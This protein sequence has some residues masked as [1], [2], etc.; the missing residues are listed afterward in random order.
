MSK[1]KKKVFSFKLTN[2]LVPKETPSADNA[3]LATEG[4]RIYFRVIHQI[5]LRRG[6]STQS[7]VI[8]TLYP[9][10]KTNEL[11]QASEYP[12]NNGYAVFAKTMDGKY[13]VVSI[14]GT[15]YCELAEKQHDAMPIE[16]E[17]K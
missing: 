14:S 5:A 2:N 4:A 13:F 6:A 17:R 10:S 11:V 8:G 9:F 7:D 12:I 16:E 1:K 3:P 15:V